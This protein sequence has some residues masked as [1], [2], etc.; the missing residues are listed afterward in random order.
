MNQM[1]EL[2]LE[3]VV[4]LLAI[5]VMSAFIGGFELAKRTFT[6]PNTKTSQTANE[7]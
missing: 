7:E 6:D 3:A 1:Q 4:I 5:C 2:K